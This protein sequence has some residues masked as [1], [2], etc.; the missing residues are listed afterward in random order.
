MDSLGKN[1]GVG[2]HALPGDL[3]NPGIKPA[4]LTSPA[5]AGRFFT[6]TATWEAPN[7]GI[8]PS[9]RKQKK[10]N[11]CQTST[12][13]AMPLTSCVGPALLQL[14]EARSSGSRK[15]GQSNEGRT[16][17]PK[18]KPGWRPARVG[19]ALCGIYNQARLRAKSQPFDSCME[20]TP[21]FYKT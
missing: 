20:N 16:G 19:L 2:C 21:F 8:I 12:K 5:L 3:P 17:T 10:E 18:N 15:Q 4:S 13:T 9:Y 7:E 1:T 6:T 11:G 14:L